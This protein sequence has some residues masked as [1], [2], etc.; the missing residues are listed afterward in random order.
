MVSFFKFIIGASYRNLT[1]I[2]NLSQIFTLAGVHAI[3]VGAD[4]EVVKAAKEGIRLALPVKFP[5]LMISV[6]L[7]NDVHFMKV[8]KSNEKCVLCGK[9]IDICQNKV[10][11]VLNSKIQISDDK[12]V[13]CKKCISVC[14]PQCL[15][16]VPIKST[17]TDIENCIKEGADAIEIHCGDGK[18]K[19]IKSMWKKISIYIQSKEEIALPISSN[20]SPLMGEDKG[21]GEIK[22]VSFSI[23]AHGLTTAK[24]ISLI[25]EIKKFVNEPVIWQIDGCPIS[26]KKG[27]ESTLPSLMLAK[28]IRK[29]Y[30]DI[31]L[32]VSGGVNNLTYTLAKEE[33]ISIDGIG[34]GSFARAY[35]NIDDM[36]NMDYETLMQAAKKARELIDF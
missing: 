9:C 5:L 3:D 2:K 19:A 1:I 25:A 4:P 6:G 17:F 29:V 20:S 21:E 26:G 27:R 18:I 31:F 35:L 10:F 34:M 36:E 24:I 7:N 30:P 23:G 22:A 12:C 13:G 8:K 14:E 32:Q 11:K 16:F 28:E 33:N 15:K